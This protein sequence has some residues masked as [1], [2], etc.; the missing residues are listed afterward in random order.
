MLGTGRPMPPYVVVP[1]LSYLATVNYYT[2]GWLGRSYD[3]LLLRS[4]PNRAAGQDAGLAPLFEV[5][6]QLLKDRVALLDA[7]NQNREM[8]DG[9][10][11]VAQG[12]SVHR[13]QAYELLFSGAAKEAFDLNLESP[14]IRDDYG[15]TRLGQ[16]CL[17]ARR[18]VEAGIPFVTVDDDGWDHHAQVF[19]ALRRSLP[20]LD[21][22]FS[23][24]LLDLDRRG[25]LATTLVL[26]LT[27]FGRTPMVNKSAGRDHWPRVF[28]VIA[29]GAGIPGG[30]V[31]GASD[32]LGGEP[33]ARPLTPKDLAAT[34]YAFLG[35]DSRSDYASNEGRPLR[36]LDDGQIIRELWG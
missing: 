3:P 24:L 10:S 35:L 31:I 8:I 7:L 11:G 9:M 30:Q 6:T 23:T 29:A 4:D 1:G 28:S 36:V 5:D 33:A 34:M 17:L 27:E 20:Q 16:S 22:A 19:P 14:K 12:M 32:R 26:L 25:L 18:L 13:R 15:R 2:A 21:Q